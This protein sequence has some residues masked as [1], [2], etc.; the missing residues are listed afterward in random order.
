MRQKTRRAWERR[1][2]ARERRATALARVERAAKGELRLNRQARA[3]ELLGVSPRTLEGW[4]VAGRGP[5]W[6]KV[7]RAVVYRTQDL[8]DYVSARS[9][10]STAAA[11][12]EAG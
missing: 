12:P 4:R 9:A 8:E 5:R 2:S 10:T 11:P 7:G 6:A 1:A 3:A